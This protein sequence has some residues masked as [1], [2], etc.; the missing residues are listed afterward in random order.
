ML[1]FRFATKLD[2]ETLIR[3]REMIENI[4]WSGYDEPESVLAYLVSQICSEAFS[5]KA[6]EFSILW[7]GLKIPT[8]DAELNILLEESSKLLVWL[9][10]TSISSSNPTGNH[11]T[12]ESFFNP[13][14]SRDW[15]YIIE[16]NGALDETDY[17]L[18]F[19]EQGIEFTL[20]FI[21]IDDRRIKVEFQPLNIN[22]DPENKVLIAE[23]YQISADI[24]NL[25][26]SFLSFI[27][28]IDIRVFN[29]L[30]YFYFPSHFKTLNHDN[31]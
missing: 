31:G 22:F 15:G 28:Q 21:K 16:K 5:L 23:A 14:K 6:V 2:D 1:E 20:N 3:M 19:F 18:H 17:L 24:S 9:G 27:R 25:I 4:D 29:S 8:C 10:S 12:A 11:C 30:T 26:F 7:D 13:I